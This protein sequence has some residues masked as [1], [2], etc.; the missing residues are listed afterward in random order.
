MCEKTGLPIRKT[1]SIENINILN[2][3]NHLQELYYV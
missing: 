3:Q 1:K 2:A